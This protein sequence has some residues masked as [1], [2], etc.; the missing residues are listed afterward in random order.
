M[1][2]IPESVLIGVALMVTLLLLMRSGAAAARCVALEPDA[3]LF[4]DPSTP[5]AFPA[6][7]V[8]RIFSRADSEFVLAAKSSQLVKLFH[9][10]RKLVALVW[11][12]QTSALIQATMRDHR[13]LARVSRDLDFQT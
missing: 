5:S 13:R 6:N 11:V 1:T 2:A 10:E 3:L 7:L 9:S 8:S 4:D 12:Q